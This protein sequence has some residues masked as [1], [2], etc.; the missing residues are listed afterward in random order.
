MIKELKDIQELKEFSHELVEH[1]VIENIHH[2]GLDY[3][4]D[5]FMIGPK[6]STLP[7]FLITAGVHGLEKIGT[8]VVIA[9]L[10][11]FF[12]QLKWDQKLCESFKHKRLIVVPLINPVG[13]SLNKRSNGNDVDLMRNA[14]LES[15]EEFNLPLISGHNYSTKLPWYRGNPNQMEKESQALVNLFKENLLTSPV[16]IALDLH[17]GFGVKDRLWYPY[18]SS[19]KGFHYTERLKILFNYL[20]KHFLTTFTLLSNSLIHILSMETCGTI[21]SKF[22]TKKINSRKKYSFHFA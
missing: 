16:S 14:P 20:K 1:N 6:D 3:P 13:M 9:F 8:H 11:S 22:I 10:Q 12:A 17:S 2:N 18:A 21:C 5:A 4:I 15:K 7:V 19:T